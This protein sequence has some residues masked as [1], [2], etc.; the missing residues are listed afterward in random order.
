MSFSFLSVF[1]LDDRSRLIE[2]QFHSF[3]V[4]KMHI[5]RLALVAPLA[6][7]STLPRYGEAGQQLLAGG[8]TPSAADFQCDLSEAIDPS[9]DGLSSA[10]KLFGSKDALLKQVA[11]HSALVQ[12]PSVCYDDLGSFDEDPRWAPFYDFHD[13]LEETFPLM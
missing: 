2:L 9:G 10:A 11:R 12:V 4:L 5:S 1:S 7:A 6:W 8:R 13:V 3:V